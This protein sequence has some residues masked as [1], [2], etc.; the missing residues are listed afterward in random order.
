[1][2]SAT[3][4]TRLPLKDDAVLDMASVLR[5]NLEALAGWAE[6]NESSLSSIRAAE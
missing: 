5:I 4:Q 1:M 2:I 6:V 3:F